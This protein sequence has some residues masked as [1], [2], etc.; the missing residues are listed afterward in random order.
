MRELLNNLLSRDKSPLV[1]LK[2]AQ[3]W[4]AKLDQDDPPTQR[5]KILQT[6]D[7][8]LNTPRKLN[9]EMLQALMA[10]DE[11]AQSGFEAICYQYISNPRMSKE[12][13]QKLWRD[14]GGFSQT[15]VLAYQRF[16]QHEPGSVEKAKFEELMPKVLARSLHYLS[17]QA[18]WYYFHFE[19]V[20]GE[21]WT[22]IHRLYR[23]SEVDGFDSNPFA[24]YAHHP[25]EVTSCADEYIQIL[26]LATVSNNNLS[27]RQLDWVD[28]WLDRWSKLIQLARKLQ[29]DR[30]HFCINL[31]APAGPQKIQPD[32]S[33]E[34][35]RYWGLF[36]M[37]SDVQDVLRRVEQGAAPK[38]LGLGSEAR[39]PASVE[40]LK[41]LDVFWTMAIRNA[42]VKR[43]ERHDV[44]KA[45]D[46][47]HG[48]D[49][50]YTHV[51]SDNDKYSRQP[52]EAKTQVDYDE[53]MDM[54]LYG[55]VSSRTRS[56]Q[57]Q[58][59]YTVP[60]KQQD[61]T[62]WEI[63]NESNGGYGAL[64]RFSDNEWVRPG[65]L[66]GLRLS[67]NENWQVCVVRRLSRKSDDEVYA[68]VQVLSSTP[69][70]VSMHS[71]EQDRLEQISVAEMSPF[72]VELPNMRTALYIPHQVE[73]ANVNTLLIRSADYSLG[74][75]YRVQARE[76]VFTVSL[77]S[78]LEKGVEWT[79][80]TVQVLRQES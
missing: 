27:V 11:A 50:I 45:A 28:Q 6:L 49:R 30:H 74:R 40:L 61:W 64:M 47:V 80:V 72:G 69:V 38:D 13:E 58:N 22:L 68:G 16:V 54:R 53:I 17:I 21:L 26:M 46:I 35:F 44:Q 39:S 2:Q 60:V 4:I 23:I 76:R 9:V 42:E 59:P 10:I 56:K 52:T 15:W 25:D 43:S 75:V 3:G 77:G 63:Q 20:P 78:V 70:A 14:I 31:Q 19:K 8:F 41:H 55:F 18:K 51:R 67:A 24:L 66:L 71:D 57:T 1:G 7:D 48:L 36:D 5:V 32:S 62:T 73:G 37:M 33:G 12:I 29:P 79:W 65:L 34:P